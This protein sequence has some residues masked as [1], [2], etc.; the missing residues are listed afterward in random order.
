MSDRNADR[1]AVR[2]KFLAWLTLAIA[3][4]VLAHAAWD[5]TE[6]RRLRAR[7]D[8]HMQRKASRRRSIRSG[9]FVIS[10]TRE[11]EAAR[12]YRAAAALASDWNRNAYVPLAPPNNILNST[13][14]DWS[15]AQR[16]AGRPSRFC[17]QRCAGLGGSRDGDRVFRVSS[18]HGLQLPI[19]G[20][21]AARTTRKPPHARAR[22]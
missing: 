14:Q 4:P 6:A 3:L 17:K 2:P 19:C 20:I 1:F 11:R 9:R 15:P 12:L 10:Q 13:P 7:V 21:V 18:R 8:A 5:Y 22:C 16:E